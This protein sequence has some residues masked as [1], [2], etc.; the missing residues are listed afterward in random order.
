MTYEPQARASLHVRPLDRRQHRHRPVRRAGARGPLAAATRGAARRGRRVGRQPAR[1]RS[2]ADRRD[3]AERDQIVARVQARRSTRPAWSCRWRPRTCSAIRSSETARSPP[4]IPRC[5]RYALQKTMRAI[6]LGAELG[7]TIYVFWGG[8]EGAETDAAKDPLDALKLLPRGAQLPVRLRRST[9]ATTC[10]SRWRPSRTSRAATSTSRRR[11]RCSPSSRRWITRRWSGVNPEV[12]HEH[13]AGLNS[14]HHVAQA[15]R[16]GQAVPH[17]PQRPDPGA[18]RPGL[19]VR[20]GEPQGRVLP[21]QV[22]RGR[23][24]RGQPPLRRPRLPHRGLRGR[25][26]FRARLHAHLPDPEGESRA[27]ERRP[28]DPSAA[29]SSQC[30]RRHRWRRTSGAY[31]PETRGGAHAK[32]ELRP[33]RPGR[34]RLSLRAAGPADHRAAAWRAVTIKPANRPLQQEE[35]GRELFLG[36]DVSTTATKAL[37]MDQEGRVVLTAA[38]A[39]TLS[40]RHNRCGANRTPP[41]GGRP[42]RK[43]SARCWEKPVA[44]EVDGVG[45][46][47][48]MHGLVMLDD[49]GP[50]LRPAILW[51]DQRTAAECDEIRERDGPRTP[52]PGHRQRRPGR[53]YRAEDPLGPQSTSPKSIARSAISCCPKT[54]VRLQLTGDYAI[55]RA[56]GSGTLL[57]DLT[58]RDWSAEVA[59][60]LGIDPVWLPRDPRRPGGHRRVSRGSRRSDRS[61]RRDTGRGGRWR[62]GGGGG[63]RRRGEPGSRLG[64]PGD[65]GCRLCQHRRAAHRTRSPPARFLPRPPG[66][67]APDG[68]DALGGGQP[69][70]VSRCAC[71]DVAFDDLSTERATAPAGQRRAALPAVPDRRA[72]AR[73][74]IRRRAARLSG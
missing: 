58:R 31:T 63:R 59:A 10:D 40:R 5:A 28:R 68:R 26:G 48:Q 11:A 19:A 45:L 3:A 6:D 36:I 42:P 23:R 12:A 60:A 53:V 14:T 64:L 50:V 30:R 47:G 43:A 71:P 2:R 24:L 70:L 29:R 55:D 39:S 7:A 25:Q 72:H 61:A 37:L 1:Q 52:D 66:K 57:F 18:L 69:A 16:C 74:P 4:T 32:N 73:I 38:T 62:P 21:R 9:R 33:A 8:R 35:R 65:L 27:V 44:T 54:I 34:A 41:F 49:Q 20:L 51:N 46:T 22:A 67:M 15:G 17:R 56:D 13:M